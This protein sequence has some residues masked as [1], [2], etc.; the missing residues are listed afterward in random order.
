MT[1]NVFMININYQSYG[2]AGLLLR[3]RLYKEGETRYVNVTKLLKGNPAKRHWNQKK[4]HFIPSAP[5]AKENNDILV[6]FRQKYEEKAINWTGSLSAFMLS[7][8][9]EVITTRRDGTS[10]HDYFNVVIERIKENRHPDGSA[11][12]TFENYEKCDK[13]IREY[14]ESINLAYDDLLLT[15]INVTFINNLLNWVKAEREGKGMVYISKMLHSVLAKA[16]K[17]G[18]LNIEPLERA[19]WCKASLAS[20]NK[21]N[22]LTE[23]QIAKL[24]K[25]MP[26]EISRSS[27]SAL[28]KDVCLFILCT[29]QSVCDALSLKYSDIR[30]FNGVRHFVF[31]RRKIAERQIVPCAVPIGKEM[32][33]IME[34]WRK[35][36]KDGYIF[37]VRSKQ[38]ISEQGTNNGEIKKFIILLNGWL[39]KLGKVLGCDFPLKSYTFRHTAIT[40][41]LSKGVPA[42]YVA[43]MM[44][45]S[46]KNCE[47]IYYNNH[48]DTRN[49]DKVL[50]AMTV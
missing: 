21:N 43:N 5:Y 47:Q 17:D 13:R 20:A 16:D 8:S 39:K 41:Y 19:R 10:L 38:K 50:A 24:K 6:V 34:K 3:L 42:I 18:L 15:D 35:S 32:D 40:Y 36:S 2:S 12:G 44:G 29:G 23:E 28:F 11:K 25:L 48:L 7:M 14:C 1:N 31:K 37:P 4:Q 49:R 26:W 9:E 30:V 46:V 33:E 45:T 22:T 27:R